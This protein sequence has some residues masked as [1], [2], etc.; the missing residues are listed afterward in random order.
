[1]EE[2]IKKVFNEKLNDGTIEKIVSEK[3]EGMISS[4]LQDQMSW[5]GQVKKQLEERLKPIML[6]AVANC[7]LSQTA[8]IV[9]D[10]LNQAV[11]TSPVHLI[12]DTYDGI[13]TLFTNNEEAQN[14][15]FGKTVKLTEIFKTYT[16]M[17]EN[18]S[19]CESDFKKKDLEIHDDYDDGG[20][21]GYIDVIM[22]VETILKKNY[23]D[24]YDTK[25]QVT[26]SNN[27]DNEEKEVV[28]EITKSYDSTLRINIDTGN[29]LLAELKHLPPILLYL[30]QLKNNWCNIE[31]DTESEMDEVE[32]K[33]DEY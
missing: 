1:M 4:I 27:Y 5:D 2:L 8:S 9:T 16:K 25:Y 14:I 26:L 13:K 29:M 33:V 17:I 21:F 10:L 22:E 24:S 31:I 11:K 20:K 23:W 28:F 30:I 19:Y 32:V 12:K 15:T 3:I 18:D 7:D 6:E